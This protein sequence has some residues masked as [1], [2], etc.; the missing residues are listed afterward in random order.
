MDNLDSV[1]NTPN[2]TCQAPLFSRGKDTI[3]NY[4]TCLK[5]C[6]ELHRCAFQQLR[7]CSFFSSM[8]PDLLIEK[9]KNGGEMRR[10]R[11]AMKEN[12]KGEK[13][14]I[15]NPLFSIL[16][17]LETGFEDWWLYARGRN[18]IAR[19]A[20]RM[21][22][23]PWSSSASPHPSSP[24]PFCFEHFFLPFQQHHLQLSYHLCLK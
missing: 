12:T 14:G 24:S 20:S 11:L 2:C 19:V 7:W 8:L 4:S 13:L 17:A 23:Q 15:L 16:C 21:V 22:G 1:F 3:F 5:G 6:I 10:C 9:E 18:E